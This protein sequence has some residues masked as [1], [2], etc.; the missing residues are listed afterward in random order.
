MSS[1]PMKDSQRSHMNHTSRDTASHPQ[2]RRIPAFIMLVVLIG[3][4]AATLICALMGQSG[5][6][7]LALLLI[8]MAVPVFFYLIQWVARLIGRSE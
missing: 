2:L 7:I 8:D 1:T 4:I 5:S 3:C 6:L